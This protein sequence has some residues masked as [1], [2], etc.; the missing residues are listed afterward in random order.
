[1]CLSVYMSVC[2]SV[3]VFVCVL[4][5]KAKSLVLVTRWHSMEWTTFAITVCRHPTFPVSLPANQFRCWL[6]PV[7]PTDLFRCHLLH[8]DLSR[9][10]FLPTLSWTVLILITPRIVS[11]NSLNIYVAYC[12]SLH[13][14]IYNSWWIV[15]AYCFV[16]ALKK[17]TLL[18]MLTAFIHLHCCISTKSVAII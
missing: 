9:Y 4:S 16:V 15:V 11:F 10:L 18:T 17:F 12:L 7:L 8:Q 13:L 1:M 6:S 3:D 5:C 2:M 14:N